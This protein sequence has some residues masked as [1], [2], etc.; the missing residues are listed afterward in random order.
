MAD[1]DLVLVYAIPLARVPEWRALGWRVRFLMSRDDLRGCGAVVEGPR[2][3][4]VP[5]YLLAEVDDERG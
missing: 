5:A 2:G 3:L 4:A 1:A